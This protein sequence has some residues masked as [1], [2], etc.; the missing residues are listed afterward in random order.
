MSI[1][2]HLVKVRKLT[3]DTAYNIY[4]DYNGYQ[5]INYLMLSNPISALDL[6]N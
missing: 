3:G 2:E 6:E 1:I 4:R 5:C